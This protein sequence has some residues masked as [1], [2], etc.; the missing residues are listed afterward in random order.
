MKPYRIIATIKVVNEDG[1]VVDH[2][3]YTPRKNDKG[4]QTEQECSGH[5][6]LTEANKM[7]NLVHGLVDLISD[8]R[9]IKS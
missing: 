5:D 7:L 1:E 8:T 4:L 6:D 3:G 9:D 2:R